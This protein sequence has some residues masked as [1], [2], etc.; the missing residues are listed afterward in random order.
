[1]VHNLSPALFCLVFSSCEPD[2]HHGC[3]RRLLPGHGRG[4]HRRAAEEEAEKVR[5]MV[6]RH[7]V[8]VPAPA[9]FHVRAQFRWRHT[10]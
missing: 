10:R 3:R 1:M 7:G 6:Q 9:G 5:E 4:G 8:P 2:N